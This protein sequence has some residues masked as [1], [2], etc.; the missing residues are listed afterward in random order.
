VLATLGFCNTG[1]A[2]KALHVFQN[3][4]IPLIVPCATGTPITAKYPAKDSYIF[5]ASARD[6][7]QA[8]MDAS[9]IARTI[10]LSVAKKSAADLYTALCALEVL[11]CSNATSLAPMHIR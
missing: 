1:V 10:C 5:R 11:D 2:M 4:Q 3:A 6:A 9:Q 7:I 8:Y